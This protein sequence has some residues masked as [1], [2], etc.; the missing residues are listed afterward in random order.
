LD[1]LRGG[2]EGVE[3]PVAVVKYGDIG[4]VV[5]GKDEGEDL[6]GGTGET[7]GV[8]AL[9]GKDVGLDHAKHSVDVTP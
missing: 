2:P 3:G 7:V 6:P 4:G 8:E 5:S 1:H 9:G